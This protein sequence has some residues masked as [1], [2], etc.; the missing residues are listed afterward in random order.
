[1]KYLLMLLCFTLSSGICAATTTSEDIV[2]IKRAMILAVES[3]RV[4]DSL[5]TE[6]SARNSASPLIIAYT[7]TLEALKAKH[8]WNP[9][10]KLKY[11][12]RSQKTLQKA[13]K[14]EPNNLEIRFMR[15]SIQHYTPAFLGY[16]N[17]LTEDRQMIVKQ[18]SNKNFGDTD[19]GLR[20]SIAKFMIAS[21]RCTSEEVKLLRKY[22]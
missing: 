17:E 22:I 1:M 7:G 4:T 18:F 20:A 3:S 21:D 10:Q 6:L 19:A 15:F 14:A 8:S 16:S 9:Y 5:Y 11:V 13:L 2:N 12:A